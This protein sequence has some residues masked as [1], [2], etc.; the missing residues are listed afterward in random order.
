MGH[1][2]LDVQPE[3]VRAVKRTYAGIAAA[4][5]TEATGVKKTPA[6]IGQAW[7]GRAA[8]TIKGD[9]TRLG[10]LLTTFTGHFETAAGALQTLAEAYDRGLEDLLTLNT[11]SMAA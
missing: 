1:Y 7:T 4:L 8:S 9:M 2:Q 10:G 3:L 11:Q 6:E 5:D